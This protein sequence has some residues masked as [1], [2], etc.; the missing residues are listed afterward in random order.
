MKNSQNIKVVLQENDKMPAMPLGP[1]LD[2]VDDNGQVNDLKYDIQS[3]FDMNEGELSSILKPLKKIY[4]ESFKKYF[5][6]AGL[7]NK[8]KEIVTI[9]TSRFDKICEVMV[10]QKQFVSGLYVAML[11]S[12]NNIIGYNLFIEAPISE[13]LKDMVNRKYIIDSYA[14]RGDFLKTNDSR[15]NDFY[16]ISLALH[17]DYQK[18]GLSRYLIFSPFWFKNSIKNIY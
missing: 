17:P 7:S 3:L 8:E 4:I 9:L 12:E 18:K 16:I 10:L 15:V 2:K 6:I 13:I 14:F 1:L 11:Y 5:D